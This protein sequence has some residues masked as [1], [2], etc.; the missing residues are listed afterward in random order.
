VAA[1]TIRARWGELLLASATKKGASTWK[2]KPDGT[3]ASNPTKRAPAGVLR[4]VARSSALLLLLLLLPPTPLAALAARSGELDTR[5]ATEIRGTRSRGLR[6]EVARSRRSEEGATTLRTSHRSTLR[7]SRPATGLG[8]DG[9]AAAATINAA[10]SS[11]SSPLPP[12]PPPSL[13]LA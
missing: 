2:G 3:S 12:L 6:S 5:A 7:T 11:P 9:R 8:T 13:T 4:S 1:V 10:P